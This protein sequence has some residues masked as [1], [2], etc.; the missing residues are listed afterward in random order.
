MISWRFQPFYV[1]SIEKVP[2]GHVYEIETAI[3][4]CVHGQ[5]RNC[6]QIALDSGYSAA[7]SIPW[8]PRPKLGGRYRLILSLDLHLH[9]RFS[10]HETR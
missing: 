5:Q 1:W 9:A 10:C 6:T 7:C 8:A 4:A 2:A 3:S